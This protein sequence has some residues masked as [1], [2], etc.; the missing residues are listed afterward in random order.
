MEL[1]RG[2][3]RRTA[4]WSHGV[5]KMTMAA[6]KKPA[7]M[8]D[9]DIGLSKGID[10]SDAA[11]RRRYGAEAGWRNDIGQGAVETII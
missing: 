7:G 4:G 3:Q 5:K 8:P 2:G 6:I 1:P 11:G 10:H 9:E